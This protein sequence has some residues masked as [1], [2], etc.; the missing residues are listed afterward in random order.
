MTNMIDM[1]AFEPEKEMTK[2]RL[3]TAILV[4]LLTS[5]LAEIPNKSDAFPKTHPSGPKSGPAGAKSILPPKKTK[6]DLYL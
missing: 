3:T 1:T 2:G 6:K 4:G 5:R